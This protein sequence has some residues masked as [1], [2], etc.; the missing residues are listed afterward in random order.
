MTTNIKISRALE[1]DVEG[2][3]NVHQD[4]W[5]STYPNEAH[6]ITR[7]DLEG[8]NWNDPARL[9]RWKRFAVST[10]P[11]KAMWVAKDESKVIGFLRAA[12]DDFE[13]DLQALYILDKYQGQG[14]GT[15]L[16]HGF[17]DWCDKEKDTTLG[18][19]SYNE[20][21]INFY[22]GFGFE[23][24]VVVLPHK[25]DLPSGKSIPEIQMVLKGNL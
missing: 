9:E 24:K 4:T 10:D 8:I 7:E 1:K 5:I 18:V 12:K 11:R 14:I 23:I 20:S 13:N 6:G 3:L 2:I 21:T 22:K 19:A 15:K 16:M 17:L 25:T